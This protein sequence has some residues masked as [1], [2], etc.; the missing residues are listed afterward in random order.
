[1]AVNSLPSWRPFSPASTRMRNRP[2]AHGHRTTAGS[3]SG[4]TSTPVTPAAGPSRW[5]PPPSPGSPGPSRYPPLP[6][7]R[8]RPIPT[9][10]KSLR[11]KILDLDRRPWRPWPAPGR[12]SP[13]RAVPGGSGSSPPAGRRATSPPPRPTRSAPLPH[14][15]HMPGPATR[16]AAGQQTAGEDFSDIPQRAG[17]TRGQEREVTGADGSGAEAGEVAGSRSGLGSSERPACPGCGPGR[18]QGQA[19]RRQARAFHAPDSRK[20]GPIRSYD[21]RRDVA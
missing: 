2:Q 20:A 4:R 7:T 17:R 14:T 19:R 6:T 18:S 13:V 10:D 12:G 15:G 11:S 3:W 8:P 9:P 1:V 5:R 16:R 21:R